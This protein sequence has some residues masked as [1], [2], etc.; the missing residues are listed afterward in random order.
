MDGAVRMNWIITIS[1]C[2]G[3]LMVVSVLPGM[4]YLEWFEAWLRYKR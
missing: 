4:V 3:V 1:T 2:L